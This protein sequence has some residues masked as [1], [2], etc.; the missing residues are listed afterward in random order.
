MIFPN[1]RG[2]LPHRSLRPAA[3]QTGSGA[4][5]AGR[6]D[7]GSWSPHA[8]GLRN[9]VLALETC[10]TGCCCHP[11]PMEM[12][13]IANDAGHHQTP[14]AAGGEQCPS[15][16]TP[17]RPTAPARPPPHRIGGAAGKYRVAGNRARGRRPQ[18]S[19]SSRSPSTSVTTASSMPPTRPLRSRHGLRR[20]RNCG[21]PGKSTQRN[22]RS[23]PGRLRAP[24]PMAVGQQILRHPHQQQIV[25]G[26]AKPSSARGARSDQPPLDPVA[27]AVGRNGE[28]AGR[29]SC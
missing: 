1:G 18:A 20:S 2:R 4:V 27:N 7:A 9:N 8:S 19:G 11:L 16:P 25:E 6:A 24:R 13:A 14:T 3:R 23:G 5:P 26:E 10:R 17:T 12:A 22:F 15:I 29:R 28:D 21:Q